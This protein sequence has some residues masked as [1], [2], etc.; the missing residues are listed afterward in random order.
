MMKSHELKV[1]KLDLWIWSVVLLCSNLAR[2]CTEYSSL[3]EG[4]WAQKFISKAN[5][6]KFNAVLLLCIGHKTWSVDQCS[7]PWLCRWTLKNKSPIDYFSSS[8]CR[9][10]K[11]IGLM[12]FFLCFAAVRLSVP[13][14]Q[15]LNYQTA[16][17]LSPG[18]V[19]WVFYILG[20]DCVCLGGPSSGVAVII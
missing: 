12:G 15:F 16:L 20:Q 17:I 7:T 19:C 4:N 18:L 11:S 13:V 5:M 2:N 1:C 14:S 3:W 8:I 6:L 10:I 9:K